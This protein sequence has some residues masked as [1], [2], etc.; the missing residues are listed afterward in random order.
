MTLTAYT[1]NEE[2]IYWK[3][4]NKS[5]A[6]LSVSGNSVTVIGLQPGKVKVT[7]YTKD[8]SGKSASKIIT[9]IVPVSDI[10]LMAE[11][12]RMDNI[13]ASGGSLQFYAKIGNQ[14][15]KPTNSKFKWSYELVCYASKDKDREVE[16]SNEL[17]A[18]IK[19][20]KEIL[21]FNKGKIT[22]VSQKKFETQWKKY[23]HKGAG[24]DYG[25]R[26]TATTADGTELSVTKLVRRIDASKKLFLWNGEIVENP[27]IN[28]E[29][30]IGLYNGYVLM[31]DANL[32]DIVITNSNP[33]V[34]GYDIR[35]TKKYNYHYLDFHGYKTGESTLTIKTMDGSNLVLKIKIIVTKR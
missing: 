24:K 25:I 18:M 12:D 20:D 34:A 30:G 14:Y 9:I 17:R 1:D 15:G 35:V 2:A 8:G 5:R 7:A 23:W 22:A 6:A 11:K 21:T 13:L 27:K 32:N 19:R 28:V 33:E 3:V 4:N 29:E 26:V 31:T 16:L 10:S